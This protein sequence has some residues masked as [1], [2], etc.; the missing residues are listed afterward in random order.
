[1]TVSSPLPHSPAPAAELAPA[2]G[3]STVEIDASCRPL[4]WLLL[5]AVAWLAVASLFGI[6]SAIKTHAPGF[7]ANYSWL[8][9][10]RVRPVSLNGLVYGFGIQA[11]FGVALWMSCRLGRN[12]LQGAG[13]I[14]VAAAVWNLVLAAGLVLVL[15]GASTGY[16]WLELPRS[17]TPSLFFAYIV[18]GIGAMLTAHARRQRMFYVSQWFLLAALLWFPWI[19][20]TAQVLLVF[21][22]V[23]GVL[24]AVVDGWYTHNLF[25]LC[26]APLGLASIFYFLPKLLQR[27]LASA[28]MALGGFWL[29]VLFGGWGGVR[30]GDPAPNWLSS[31]SSVARVLLLVPALM[32]AMN[33][34]QTAARRPSKKQMQPEA[35]SLVRFFWVAAASYVV[36]EVLETAGS[37]PGINRIA[38]FTLYDAGIAQLRIHGFLAMALAGAVYFI[39]PRL[40]GVGWPSARLVQ[41]HFWCSVLGVALTVIPLAVGGMMQGAGIDNPQLDFISVVR[42]TTPFLGT[43]TLGSTLL[44]VGYALFF[45]HFARLLTV[46][47]PCAAFL[48]AFRK[49]VRVSSAAG[50][51][52]A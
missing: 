14:L 27:P 50:G 17:V 31:V 40:A 43:S 12:L 4:L 32:F 36:A 21:F 38:Q 35:D 13:A 11:G 8:T 19:Y 25:E 20:S 5:A 9:Y 34:Y 30:M 3:A 23:R 2:S 16:E 46:N 49:S 7:L 10:G 26:I 37:L 41:A 28:P 22:P 48:E 15:A 42:R 51:A 47:C 44:G 18:M 6:V 24:Q 39:A 1:M 45:L 52:K 29:L 33:W